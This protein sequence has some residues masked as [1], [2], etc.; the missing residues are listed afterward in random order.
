MWFETLNFF[1]RFVISYT[2][3]V[4]PSFQR[5]FLISFSTCES[6][7]RAAKRRQ[8]VVEAASSGSL[9]C[10][11]K[12]RKTSGTRVKKTKCD[13]SQICTPADTGLTFTNS[14]VQVGHISPKPLEEHAVWLRLKTKPRQ[15][16]LPDR[17]Q[18]SDSPMRVFCI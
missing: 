18:R 15:C 10:G 17:E 14:A 7:E 1:R 13:S 16:C 9:S 8:R 11:E 6:R 5:F 12:T 3:A 4:L 2:N